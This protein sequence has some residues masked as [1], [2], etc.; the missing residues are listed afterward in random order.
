M[1]LPGRSKMS[2]VLVWKSDT[3]GKLFEDKLKYTKHLR[4]LATE[5]Q[6]DRKIAAQQAARAA[7][8]KRMGDTVTSIT[9]LEQF[10]V[11]NW[12]WF[13]LNGIATY[14]HN[15]Q[16]NGTKSPKQH[17]I[18]DIAFAV[19]W[20]KSVSNTHCCPIGGVTNWDQFRAPPD[21]PKGY[22]GW[23]GTMEATFGVVNKQGKETNH[24]SCGGG[25]FR[26]TTINT[27]SGG[28]C[29]KVSY[30]VSLFESDFP[31]MTEARNAE[32]IVAKLLGKPPVVGG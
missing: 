11:A 20:N 6:Y 14:D 30:G 21:K 13:A 4:K 22:P 23:S 27:G 3:D 31:A 25:Y 10:I 1:G 8:I 29:H 19:K 2:Q 18:V 28:G 7:F 5:R 17:T 32:I 16:R 24:M 12:E 15:H 26:D 9:E